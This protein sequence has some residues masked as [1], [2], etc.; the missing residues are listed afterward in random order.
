MLGYKINE[1]WEKRSNTKQDEFNKSA[2]IR[3]E[4][5]LRS[6]FSPALKEGI[7][8]ILGIDA[9]VFIDSNDQQT[10]I[11]S[12]PKIFNTSSVDQSI[13]LEIGALAAWSPSKNEDIAPYAA[14]YYPG[15]FTRNETKVL[16]VAPERTFWEKATILHHEANRPEHLAMPL[17]Y[18]RHYFD[19]YCMSKTEVKNIAVNNFELLDKVAEF[20]AKFYPRSWAKYNDAKPGSLKLMPPVY[21]IAALKKD[22]EQMQDMIFGDRPEFD[23]MMTQ[24]QQLQDEIN[25]S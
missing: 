5:F 12:Y 17:R 13:R 10:I 8:Q 24:I 16:T 15:L 19:L 6:C 25:H 11:F 9:N 2:N 21:N 3:A 22:Y 18:S 14:K 20:K 4:D 1:P 23:E 7:S